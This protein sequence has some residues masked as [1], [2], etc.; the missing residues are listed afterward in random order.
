MNLIVRHGE[1]LA[2]VSGLLPLLGAIAAFVLGTHWVVVVAGAV[3]GGFL[4]LLMRSYVELVRVMA[5]MLIPK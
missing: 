1:A 5:D 3:A 4:Y 2:V